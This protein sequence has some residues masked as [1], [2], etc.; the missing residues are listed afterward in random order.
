[1]RI[2]SELRNLIFRL[3]VADGWSVTSVAYHLRLHRDSVLRTL[4]TAN[5]RHQKSN[6]GADDDFSRA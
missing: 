6:G 3:L 5:S 4:A 2:S 1:M